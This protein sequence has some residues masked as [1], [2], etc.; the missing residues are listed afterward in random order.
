MST[1]GL[2]GLSLDHSFS[3]AFFR[4]FFIERG[5]SNH[6]YSSIEI[7]DG[8]ELTRFFNNSISQYS[9]LNVTLPYKEAVMPFLHQLDPIAQ[10]IA[11]VNVIKVG[12]GLQ[13]KGYNTDGPAFLD[14]LKEWNLPE[15]G[16]ALVLGNGGASKA[17]QWALNQMD[18]T[19]SIVSRGVSKETMEYAHLQK[20]LVEKAS[21][22][23]N[24]TPLGMY[25]KVKE[26]PPFPF[27]GINSKHKV[28]DLIYNPEKTLFLQLA[29]A[30]GARI[31]NGHEMLEKQALLSWDIWQEAE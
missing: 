11:A 7:E 18:Y 27:D 30:K 20:R 17:V 26:C 14:T 16:F 28:Y 15:R 21:L 31:K 25:P 2:I 24:T 12:A 10:S 22:I 1:Y 3:P 9:G 5:L 6:T 4:Q 8:E 23:I 29:E 19:Y 13:L